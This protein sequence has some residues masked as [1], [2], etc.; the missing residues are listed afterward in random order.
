[1]DGLKLGCRKSKLCSSK[2]RYQYAIYSRRYRCSEKIA[3]FTTVD[4]ESYAYTA[5][6][7]QHGNIVETLLTSRE[8]A[9]F[10]APS[11]QDTGEHGSGRRGCGDKPRQ[12]LVF[13][14]S[15]LSDW[16]NQEVD[17]KAAHSKTNVRECRD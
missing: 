13:R 3:P 9:P 14:L 4:E 7:G 16:I 11:L 6:A 10:I 12:E 15:R 8:S 17:S 2:L 1:M 5:N